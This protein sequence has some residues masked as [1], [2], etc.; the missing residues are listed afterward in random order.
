MTFVITHGYLEHGRKPW[1]LQL[2]DE[3]LAHGDH[4]VV[5]VDWLS[6]SR[7]P[8]TQAAA[9]TR[10]VASMAAAFLAFLRRAAGLDLMHVHLVGHSLGAHLC[11]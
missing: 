6:A 5:V 10:L 2:R 11:G 9:N 4:N 1:L 8:Y 7:P 3:L